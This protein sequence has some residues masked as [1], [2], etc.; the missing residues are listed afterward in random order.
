MT[1]GTLKGYGRIPVS[2][3]R[4]MTFRLEDGDARDVDLTSGQIRQEHGNSCNVLSFLVHAPRN[5]VTMATRR[6]FTRSGELDRRH[7]FAWLSREVDRQ[8][9]EGEVPAFHVPRCGE[10]ADLAG[11]IARDP[12]VPDADAKAVRAWLDRHAA[13]EKLVREIRDWPRQADELMKRCPGPDAAPEALADWRSR[14]ECSLSERWRM[15]WGEGPHAA[16]AAAMPEDGERLRDAWEPMDG[17]VQASMR[18]ELRGRE[19]EA[20]RQTEAAGGIAFDAPAWGVL[21]ECMRELGARA[22]RSIAVGREIERLEGRDARWKKDR[23]DVARVMEMADAT[24][25]A[26]DGIADL[27]GPDRAGAWLEEAG[28]TME[29]ERA[30]PEDMT[31]RERATHLAAAGRKPE[32]L[33]EAMDGIGKLVVQE[34]AERDRR[35]LADDVL[36]LSCAVSER[37]DAAS[38]VH[39]DSLPRDI[40][41]VLRSSAQAR[42]VPEAEI[43]KVAFDVARTRAETDL[44]VVAAREVDEGEIFEAR[45]RYEGD[46]DY[47]DREDRGAYDAAVRKLAP[48]LDVEDSLPT[49]REIRVA[50]AVV[51]TRGTE[52]H[53]LAMAIAEALELGTT[54]TADEIR[55]ERAA[56][57]AELQRDG[58]QD[59]DRFDRSDREQDLLL[60]VCASFT[61]A[62]VR[63]MC[64]GKGAVARDFGL[65]RD[66]GAERDRGMYPEIEPW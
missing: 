31:D 52:G 21:K 55:D 15:L 57:V 9:T 18:D 10:L 5:A 59:E 61:G 30:L 34:E 47:S 8:T 62:E 12:A 22:D 28:R 24:L 40:A 43:R 14:A 6:Q 42:D 33:D 1:E 66:R 53:E 17:L 32:A 7:A 20:E 44:R 11:E 49:D 36:V 27:S 56:L 60:R 26:H 64:D 41:A 4:R 39:R 16:H 19:A 38:P 46:P 35:R 48:L 50:R 2:G 23:R 29:I 45:A 51:A 58:P 37:V 54:A 65:V 3:K 63:A 13:E 25:R